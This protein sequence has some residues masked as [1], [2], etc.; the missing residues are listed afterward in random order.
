VSPVPPAPLAPQTAE[1]RPASGTTAQQQPP[2]F[3]G[4]S[5]K[6]FLRAKSPRND[7]QRVA[8]LAYYL[9]Q[10]KNTAQFKAPDIKAMNHDA[11]GADFANLSSTLAN[12]TVQNR[13]FAPVGGGKRRLTNLG[14]LV[15]EA[16]PDQEAVKQII[17]G[18]RKPRKRGPQRKA[19][20]R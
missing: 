7:T 3:T 11:R 9:T 12:A 8:C 13:F 2:A 6:E 4:Q 18:Q 20:T 5:A 19:Q 16:L 14:E 15:V 1:G 10:Q 17:S